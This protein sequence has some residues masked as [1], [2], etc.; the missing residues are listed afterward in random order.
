MEVSPGTASADS[1]PNPSR[2]GAPSPNGGH[3][4]FGRVWLV[5]DSFHLD[6]TSWTMEFVF[7]ANILELLG[8][9]PFFVK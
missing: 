5:G 4:F 6:F 7:H 1:H 9:I 2:T 8:D 3:L